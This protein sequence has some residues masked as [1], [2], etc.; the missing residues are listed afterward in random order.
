MRVF[1]RRCGPLRKISFNFEHCSQVG[2]GNSSAA[3]QDW[4]SISL[5]NDEVYSSLEKGM[6]YKG[7][8][9]VNKSTLID[10]SKLI[11]KKI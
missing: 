2:V 11:H 9:D 1:H 10:K 4:A 3:T 6:Y 8:I 5:H 7:M